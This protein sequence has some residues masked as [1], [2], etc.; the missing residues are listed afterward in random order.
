MIY[1]REGGAR[2]VHVVFRTGVTRRRTARVPVPLI[3]LNPLYVRVR[4]LLW[5]RALRS[6]DGG[7]VWRGPL[8][9][10]QCDGFRSISFDGAKRINARAAT[11]GRRRPREANYCCHCYLFAAAASPATARRLAPDAAIRFVRTTRRNTVNRPF[12]STLTLAQVPF[13]SNRYQ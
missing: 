6:A 13:C 5:C 9:S 8:A 7:S 10:L 12:L 4:V 11:T 3:K 1:K 2:A